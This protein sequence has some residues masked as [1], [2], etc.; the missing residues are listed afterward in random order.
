METVILMSI[1]AQWTVV[2]LEVSPRAKTTGD[3]YKVL[4]DSNSRRK[5]MFSRSHVE[6]K[7]LGRCLSAVIN[8]LSASDA[9]SKGLIEESD[10]DDA[11]DTYDESLFLP[12][13]SEE[14]QSKSSSRSNSPSKREKKSN[15]P[16]PTSNQDPPRPTGV[17]G[18]PSSSLKPRP[19]GF[20]SFAPN[21]EKSQSINS[22]ASTSKA[23]PF[24]TQKY[25]Q[26]GSAGDRP[27]ISTGSSDPS[28]TL[29]KE[30]PTPFNPFR[31][32]AGQPDQSSSDA[33]SIFTSKPQTSNPFQP[34]GGV[35]AAAQPATSSGPP[36]GLSFGRPSS[37][38]PA[39]GPINGKSFSFGN[40][41]SDLP[42]GGQ[43]AQKSK[44]FGQPS[45]LKDTRDTAN[46]HPENQSE[47]PSPFQ[48]FANAT[49]TTKSTEAALAVPPQTKSQPVSTSEVKDSK[50]VFTFSSSAFETKA[51]PVSTS[52]VKASAPVFTF[53]SPPPQASTNLSQRDPETQSEQRKTAAPGN[54]QSTFTPFGPKHLSGSSAVFSK[55]VNGSTT[56]QDPKPAPFTDITRLGQSQHA[57][58]EPSPTIASPAF[59]QTQFGGHPSP[60]DLAQ[61]LQPHSVKPNE[62]IDSLANKPHQVK[63]IP[64]P[65]AAPQKSDNRPRILDHL[66][67][68]LMIGEG[69]LLEQF[70]E[71]KI[72]PLM[73][74]CALE[75]KDEQ[76]WAVASPFSPSFK[77]RVWG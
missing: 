40:Q 26:I 70:V 25:P 44:T 1:W 74:T 23:N 62:P 54:A 64:P 52:E 31:K 63:S 58:I 73:R 24:A 30:T 18:Q 10:V 67:Q 39:Q 42:F 29:F 7:R 5:Q 37:S 60:E 55:P 27:A 35:P 22:T 49:S 14:E 33:S 19:Q 41:N 66:A 45:D 46:S 68:S 50:P 13:S 65:T 15:G 20:E 69:G 16:F 32:P 72:R 9:T 61:N 43:Q 21:S 8:G 2:S 71:F 77:S 36:S 4:P 76:S 6:T 75:F 17:F 28:T 12:E 51:Q 53:S 56:G 57:S 38:L 59:K 11:S 3:A 34:L 48:G 47:P